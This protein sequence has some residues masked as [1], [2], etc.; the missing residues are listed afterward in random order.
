MQQG[1]ECPRCGTIWGPNV[2]MCNCKPGGVA[3]GVN[4]IY[5]EPNLCPICHGDLN[6]PGTTSCG[7]R[8]YGAYCD[9]AKSTSFTLVV[10]TPPSAS[11]LEDFALLKSLAGG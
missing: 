9:I 8:H 7:R 3:T 6:D 5:P 1:W 4:L 11:V 10:N 2:A